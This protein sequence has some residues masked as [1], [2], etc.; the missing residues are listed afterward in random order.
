MEVI[1]GILVWTIAH[2]QF[3]KRLDEL[4]LKNFPAKT[5]MLRGVEIWR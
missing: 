1:L 2:I 4:E 5:K 3:V